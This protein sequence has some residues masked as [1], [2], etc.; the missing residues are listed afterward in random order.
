[1]KLKRSP[2]TEEGLLELKEVFWNW[3]RS[4]GTEGGLLELKEVSWN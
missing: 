2:G 1:M 3:G 4:P